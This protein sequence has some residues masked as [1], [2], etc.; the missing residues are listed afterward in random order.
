MKIIAFDPGTIKVGW[1]VFEVC[2]SPR[3][4]ESGLI[5]APVKAPIFERLREIQ[6][7][8]D[9]IANMFG[10]IDY[11]AIEAGFYKA[12]TNKSSDALAMAR[13]IIGAKIYHATVKEP[14]LIP[15]STAKKDATGNGRADKDEMLKI[16]NMRFKLAIKS[17]DEADAI[18]IGFSASLKLRRGAL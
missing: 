3:L 17:E 16:I 12:G 18:A 14:V 2:R 8:V 4:I 15:I 1:A 7:H 13:G 11:G 9:R 6:F 5:K 10:L